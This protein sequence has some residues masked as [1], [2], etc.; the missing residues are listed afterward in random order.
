MRTHEVQTE[1]PGAGLD[2]R[3]G[4]ITVLVDT[5]LALVAR[6]V[7]R[8]AE[9]LHPDVATFLSRAASWHG[10]VSAQLY[11]GV[12]DGAAWLRGALGLDATSTWEGVVGAWT[13][14][15]EDDGDDGLVMT[16]TIDGRAIVSRFEAGAGVLVESIAGLDVTWGLT[17]DRGVLVLDSPG[18]TQRIEAHPHHRAA[19]IWSAD[20]HEG[21]ER[22]GGFR[23]AAWDPKARARPLPRLRERLD[24]S[25]PIRVAVLGGGLAGLTV[26]DALA[27]K[28]RAY[29]RLAAARSRHLGGLGP[30]PIRLEVK[31]FQL[32]RELGGKA[33]SVSMDAPEGSMNPK[34]PVRFHMTHG[35][36][37]VWGYP[38]FRALLGR[39]LVDAHLAPKR[40]TSAYVTWLSDRDTIDG[41]SRL[42]TLNVC[43]PTTPEHAR[44]PECRTLLRLAQ[45]APDLAFRLVEKILHVDLRDFLH[46]GDIVLNRRELSATA[47]WM[48]LVGAIEARRLRDPEH[49]VLPML[50]GL[51]KDVEY[52][53]ALEKIVA[54]WRGVLAESVGE[55]L[56]SV[57]R[58]VS[59]ATIEE[60]VRELLSGGTGDDDQGPGLWSRLTSTIAVLGAVSVADVVALVE[61]LRDDLVDLVRE[62]PNLDFSKHAYLRVPLD[63]AFSSPYALD[64]ATALRDAKYGT[65]SFHSSL[66]QIFDGDDPRAVMNA[67]ADRASGDRDG[68]FVDVR[69]LCPAHAI[70]RVP[71]TGELQVDYYRELT[72]HPPTWR[73][74]CGR[75]DH[76]H[77]APLPL[78]PWRADL[79]V[80]T[81]PAPNLAW[82][83]EDSKLAAEPEVAPLHH[84]ASTIAKHVNETLNL[85]LFFEE[86]IELPFPEWSPAN[87]D[88]PFSISGIE[89]PFTILVDLRRACTKARF[90]EVRLRAGDTHPFDG[91][92][93]DLVGAYAEAFTH[94]PTLL[95]SR[96][97]PRDVQDELAELL[98]DP[99]EHED[100]GR[101][102]RAWAYDWAKGRTQPVM[103][104]VKKACS[105]AYGKRWLERASPLVVKTA[106]KTLL[107]LPGWDPVERAKL[108]RA[109]DGE[110]YF[111]ALARNCHEHNKFVSTEP[112]MFDAR[113]HARF[114][115]RVEGLYLAGDWTRSGSNLICMDSTVSSGLFAA[116]AVLER[117]RG[118]A[119]EWRRLELPTLHP[120]C[121]PG[122]W[123]ESP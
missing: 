37:F 50:R 94:N 29:N 40:G 26:V 91:T 16:R 79:V 72:R 108:E 80:S 110:T 15:F 114:E 68:V 58:L 75:Y 113:P 87:A 9:E 55:T 123:D 36:H 47:R 44:V 78:E 34:Q 81:I 105:P 38:H 65:R 49:A 66:V 39:E 95:A 92:A 99:A 46:F 3:A 76:C 24:P 88:P 33:Q 116:E 6:S 71:D 53:T 35:L 7:S 96:Q 102:E 10:H 101:D 117:L 121:I 119:P 69:R 48:L 1:G 103:G 70:R 61:L 63:A 54:R 21:G 73:P 84:A 59:L 5:L 90:E 42:T 17:I 93:W 106:L 56:S 31:L 122:G 25:K 23:G 4:T 12:D 45:V 89:G 41:A 62:L 32:G 2:P 52:L 82:L 109:I 51:P 43:D 19:V 85:Q 111:W 86:R 14:T 97:W 27:S 60:L 28:V 20:V 115:S 98:H 8:A 64:T 104:E 30:T 118:S 77:Y 67:I 13:I 83:L 74:V 22:R 18:A 100:D 120:E 112:G 57:A 107:A 11:D